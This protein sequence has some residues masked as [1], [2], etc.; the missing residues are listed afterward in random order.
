MK[1][2]PNEGEV[3]DDNQVDLNLTEEPATIEPEVEKTA[4]KIKSNEIKVKDDNLKVSTALS[5]PP[6][7]TYFYILSAYNKFK[8]NYIGQDR[9]RVVTL[10]Y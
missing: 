5:P 4:V 3:K 6:C 2:K 7:G 8:S 9:S 1:S 10:H